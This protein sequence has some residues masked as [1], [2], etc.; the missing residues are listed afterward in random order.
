MTTKRTGLSSTPPVNEAK[1]LGTP[2]PAKQPRAKARTDRRAAVR[3]A[4]PAPALDQTAAEKKSDIVEEKS[5][6]QETQAISS[7]TESETRADQAPQQEQ[8][9]MEITLNRSDKTRKSSSIVYTADGFR[10][11][12][13][14]SKTYFANGTAPDQLTVA[15]D[16]LAQP[17][18]KMTAEERKAARKLAPKLT[19][20]QR[21]EQLEA[22]AAKMREKLAKIAA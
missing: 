2:K 3:Q 11:S 16:A 1:A 19:P 17:K 15:T 21:L 9:R 7:P 20:Q 18:A 5:C 6:N 8:K 22:R 4:A 10:G 13:R 14:V 12:L